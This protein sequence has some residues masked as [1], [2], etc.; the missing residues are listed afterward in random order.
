MIDKDARERDLERGLLSHLRDFLLELGVGFAFVGSQHRIQVGEEEFFV[1]LL[2]YDLIK[3]QML[4]VD[5]LHSPAKNTRR[6]LD[7]WSCREL[8]RCLVG[9]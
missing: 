7:P 9:H 6:R 3:A 5:R 4:R 8:I 1:D 2:S